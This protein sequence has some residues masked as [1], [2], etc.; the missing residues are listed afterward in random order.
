MSYINFVNYTYLNESNHKSKSKSVLAYINLEADGDKYLKNIKYEKLKFPDDPQFRERYKD[1]INIRNPVITINGEDYRPR[2]EIIVLNDK[3]EILVD[4][5]KS[6]TIF[7][8]EL[9]GGGIEKNESIENAAKRECEEEVLVIP[10]QVKFANIIYIEKYIPKKLYDGRFTFVCI[11]RYKGAYKGYVK[12]MDRDDIV[13]RVTWE[14]IEDIKLA[15]PHKIAIERYLEM[16][17]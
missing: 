6:N 2:A 11:G 4:R 5:T 12:K 17:T 8:Y 7:G 3:N 13:N 16:E 15:K 9:P 1:F 14:N 10:K